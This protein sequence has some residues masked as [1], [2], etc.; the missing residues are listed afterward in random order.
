MVLQPL[1]LALILLA[2]KDDDEVLI[3]GLSFVA[4]LNV[5]RLCRAIPVLVDS[6]SYQNWNISTKD[7]I[8]KI[9]PRTKA[10][11]LVHYA[12]YPCDMDEITDL[13]LK[14]NIVLI[15][16][17]AHAVG[18]KY[19]GRQCG[20]FGDIGCFSFFTN[21]NLSVGEGGMIVTKDPE[22]HEK[23]RLLRSHGMTSLS[24]DRHRGKS[25]SYDVLIPGLNYRID[26]MR[27]ALGIVQLS[28]LDKNNTRRSHWSVII[29]NL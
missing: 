7:I 27:S 15:E 28:K 1:H 3:S 21:K 24:I 10:L 18:A 25:I 13:C 14:N 20:T 17:T 11:I 8:K 2:L 29:K 19:N 23:I 9:T 4:A 6:K 26:E 5:T 22:L 12:G 16:D